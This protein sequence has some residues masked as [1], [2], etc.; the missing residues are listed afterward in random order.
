VPLD[1]EDAQLVDVSFLGREQQR[2]ESLYLL[3]ASLLPLLADFAGA[4][5]AAIDGAVL[6][7]NGRCAGVSVTAGCLAP[8][9]GIE[10]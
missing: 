2:Q 5:R 8:C 7:D 4:E 3:D 10:S 1:F 6:G 9:M